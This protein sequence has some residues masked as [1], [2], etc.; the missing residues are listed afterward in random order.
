MIVHGD[1][2]LSFHVL[3]HSLNP[4][5][6]YLYTMKSEPYPV[7]DSEDPVMPRLRLLELE[8]NDGDNTFKRA[9]AHHVVD[10]S[11]E[12]RSAGK[13]RVVGLQVRSLR[14]R[15]LRDTTQHHDRILQIGNSDCTVL[16]GVCWAPRR[17]WIRPPITTRCREMSEA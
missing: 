8:R 9:P 3:S 16:A 12:E 17:S 6:L 15:H 4:A 10:K 14:A 1:P 5:L 2:A 11:R 7:N 13:V